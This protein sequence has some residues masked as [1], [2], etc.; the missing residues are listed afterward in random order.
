MIL[1]LV[2]LRCARQHVLQLAVKCLLFEVNRSQKFELA[3]LG[4]AVE[5]EGATVSNLFSWTRNDNQRPSSGGKA[6]QEPPKG[7]SDT[8]PAFTKLIARKHEIHDDWFYED[9]C[10]DTGVFFHRKEN[11]SK[12]TYDTPIFGLLSSQ[13]KKK[14]Y[15]SSKIYFLQPTP[16][17]PCIHTK[18][19][20]PAPNSY[21]FVRQLRLGHDLLAVGHGAVRDALAVDNAPVPFDERGVLEAEWEA[22]FA[23]RDGLE[24][25]RVPE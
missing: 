4:G 5:N 10:G 21:V 16:L 12:C 2:F 22:R 24:N 9:P 7:E 17:V 6:G 13:K 25:T 14:K 19:N 1:T 15:T 8:S 23:D 11:H 18:K 3:M 20:T